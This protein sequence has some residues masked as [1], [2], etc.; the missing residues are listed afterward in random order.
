MLNRCTCYFHKL[1]NKKSKSGFYRYCTN[2]ECVTF[3][4][5]AASCNKTCL[6][7][8]AVHFAVGVTV[9]KKLVGTN[10]NVNL[11]HHKYS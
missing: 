6:Y 10:H 8:K 5:N 11:S 4:A 2:E 7:W 1:A 3:V 9:I